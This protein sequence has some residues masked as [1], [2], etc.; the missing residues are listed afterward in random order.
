MTQVRE[1]R[2]ENAR[3]KKEANNDLFLVLFALCC[4][5]IC[6]RPFLF[7]FVAFSQGWTK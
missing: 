5:Y 4:V 6:D 3:K 2:I 7:F 1:S